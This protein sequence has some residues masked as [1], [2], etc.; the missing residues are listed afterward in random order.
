[1][2]EGGG[3]ADVL[4]GG[5]DGTPNFDFTGKLPAAWPRTA[6]MA[7]GELF[8][9]GYGLTYQSP[10]PAWTALPEDAGASAAGDSRT[11]LA[12]GVPASSWSLHIADPSQPGSQTRL[13]TFPAEALAGRARITV[14]DGAVQEGARR[15]RISGGE[16][17]VSLGTF[18]PV[19]ISREANGDV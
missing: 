2:S 11:F 10:A 1:G 8:P 12:A 16:S 15:F 3:L 14:E 5:A 6:D 4:V 19:D 13:T 17:A 18:E 9:F 7:E